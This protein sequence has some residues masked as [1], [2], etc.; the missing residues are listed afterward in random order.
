MFGGNKTEFRA[1]PEK[2]HCSREAGATEVSKMTKGHASWH[3]KDLA[4][5]VSFSMDFIIQKSCL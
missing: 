1:K 3:K 5:W 2:L 4:L